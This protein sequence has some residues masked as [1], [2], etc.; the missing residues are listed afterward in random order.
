MLDKL[1]LIASYD[2]SNKFEECKDIY[3][4]KYFYF[5]QFTISFSLVSKSVDEKRKLKY[6]YFIIPM[7]ENKI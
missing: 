7:P 5:N 2:F 6:E 3:I 1:D 4:L